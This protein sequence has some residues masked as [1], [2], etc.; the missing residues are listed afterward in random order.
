MKKLILFLFLSLFL[1]SCTQD[2]SKPRYKGHVYK[3]AW[4]RR[5]IPIWRTGTFRDRNVK[6]EAKHEMVRP[7]IINFDAW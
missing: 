3:G 6:K 4:H 2:F 7:R 1:P 5:P